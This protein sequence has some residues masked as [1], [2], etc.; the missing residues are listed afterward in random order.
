MIRNT[1]LYVTILQHTPTLSQR[2]VTHSP[3]ALQVMTLEDWQEL[4][5]STVRATDAGAFFFFISW[6]ILSKY[7]F[8]TLFL[9]VV[10]EAFERSYKNLEEEEHRT[11]AMHAAAR[12]LP[13]RP[14]G[15]DAPR[16]SIGKHIVRTVTMRRVTS[17][18][19]ATDSAKK[20]AADLLKSLGRVPVTA[21]SGGPSLDSARAQVARSRASVEI[22]AVRRSVEAGRSGHVH[23]GGRGSVAPVAEVSACLLYTSPSPRD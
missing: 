18:E 9:A 8:L 19:Q 14:D 2:T 11:V 3:L 4:M 22:N 6:V 20:E 21:R 10:M 5:M 17:V 12:S 16:F 13:Q 15:A 7:V 23:V 1:Q